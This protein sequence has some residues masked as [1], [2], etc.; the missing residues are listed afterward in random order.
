[1][2]L[3]GKPATPEALAE[4][5]RRRERYIRH[6]YIPSLVVG[7]S[8][9]LVFFLAVIISGFSIMW[10]A[11]AMGIGVLAF[12][13]NFYARHKWYRCPTCGAQIMSY[14]EGEN[15]NPDACHKCCTRLTP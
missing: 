10:T 12:G 8:A 7:A 9:L 1:M 5:A 11:V 13:Y 3:V 15:L 14:S 2:N 4:F 6:G